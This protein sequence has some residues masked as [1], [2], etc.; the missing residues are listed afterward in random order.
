MCITSSSALYHYER[1]MMNRQ[2]TDLFRK[3]DVFSSLMGKNIVKVLTI[4]HSRR[5]PL[6]E[7]SYITFSLHRSLF[8]LSITLLYLLRLSP[9][10]TMKQVMPNY[11][12]NNSPF[13]SVPPPSDIS[14]LAFDT[15]DRN[16]MRRYVAPVRKMHEGLT[17]RLP[18]SDTI[19]SRMKLRDSHVYDV[20]FGVGFDDEPFFV[21]LFFSLFQ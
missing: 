11:L 18:S 4:H 10:Q 16:V 19:V 8:F 2:S 1:R 6:G 3:S 12:A 21:L 20:N 17:R 14:F 13:V 7:S 5:K 9:D 15:R